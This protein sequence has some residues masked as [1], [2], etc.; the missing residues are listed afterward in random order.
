M[1]CADSCAHTH[2]HKKHMC[3]YLVRVKVRWQGRGR[4]PAFCFPCGCR[5]S[6]LGPQGC[7]LS[8]GHH[9]AQH[10]RHQSKQHLCVCVC[11]CVWVRMCVIEGHHLAQHV[12]HQGNCT[13]VC[14][15]VCVCV[16]VT[17]TTWHST[18]QAAFEVGVRGGVHEHMNSI[19]CTLSVNG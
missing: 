2:T 19:K 12:L 17:D 6:L 5:H 10:V 14:T 8:D 18:P 13:C 1:M 15:C 11:V 3:T 16:C 7:T 9:L 4:S